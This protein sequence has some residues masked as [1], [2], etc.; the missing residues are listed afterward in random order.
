MF[1]RKKNFNKEEYLL[2]RNLLLDFRNERVKK[3]KS[4][5][6]VNDLLYRLLK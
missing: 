6:L 2:L 4:I 1:G 3:G 5:D